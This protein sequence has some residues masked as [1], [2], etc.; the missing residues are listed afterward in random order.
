MQ[1][2]EYEKLDDKEK[3]GAEKP[4]G[5]GDPKFDSKAERSRAEGERLAQKIGDSGGLPSGDN[6][7]GNLQ[8]GRA[9]CRERV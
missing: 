3:V 8:I 7:G 9:S 2:E 6:S 1:P 5:S 4:E